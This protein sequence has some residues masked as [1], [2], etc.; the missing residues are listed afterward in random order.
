MKLTEHAIQSINNKTTR[1]KLGLA[2]NMTEQWITKLISANTDNS[3]LTL[4][5]SLK[6]IREETGLTDEEI[7]EAENESVKI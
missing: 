2:L 7:L 1:L 6:L 3:A 5:A 4:A